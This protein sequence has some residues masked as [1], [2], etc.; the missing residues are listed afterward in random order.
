[1]EETCSMLEE[2]Y[3]QGIRNIIFTP[4]YRRGMFA[5]SADD[6]EAVYKDV[7]ERF[8]DT[9]PDMKFYLGCEYFADAEIVDRL[10]D[11]RFRMDGGAAVLVEFSTAGRFETIRKVT[12][13]LA[14]EGYVPV[15]AHAERY[16][17]LYESGSL[18]PSLKELGAVIQINAGTVLGKSGGRAKRFCMDLIKEDLADIIASDAH[19]VKDRPVYMGP[20]IEKIEKKFGTGKAERLFKIN[21]SRLTD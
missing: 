13:R 8:A 3:S 11:R 5:L 4:H 10:R 1:M 21:P 12:G 20:C 14:K 16:S 19:N 17:C 15:I 18:I 9:F 7:C 6:H 2:E